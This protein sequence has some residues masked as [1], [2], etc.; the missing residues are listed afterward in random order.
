MLPNCYCTQFRRSAQALTKIYDE[1]LKPEKIKVTQL[2]LLRMLARLGPA[3]FQDLADEAS[4]DKT[5]ISRNVKILAAAGWVKIESNDDRRTKIITLT[6]TGLKKLR[7]AN[8]HW[9]RTQKKI[10]A[11]AKAV[12]L[13]NSNDPLT[14][15]LNKLQSLSG[16]R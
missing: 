16:S 11:S 6:A 4:L 13:S 5:T 15:T 8:R 7:T 1:A 12:F 10:L 14:D 9:M 2:S 3:T